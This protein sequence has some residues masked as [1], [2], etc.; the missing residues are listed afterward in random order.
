MW[1]HMHILTESTLIVMQDL[2][3]ET[4]N[5]NTV[6]DL[7]A[8]SQGYTCMMPHSPRTHASCRSN[9]LFTLWNSYAKRLAPSYFTQQLLATGDLLYQAQVSTHTTACVNTSTCSSYL[10]LQPTNPIVSCPDP[11]QLTRGK[12]VWCHK[13]ECLG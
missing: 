7:G 8:R 4:C 5:C 10:I 2:C 3:F 9:T 13:S 6:W 1:V 11:T 12:G